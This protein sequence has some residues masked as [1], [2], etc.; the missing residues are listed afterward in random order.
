MSRYQPYLLSLLRII[1]GFTFIPHGCQKLFGWL[2]GMGGKGGTAELF[3]LPWIAGVLELFG[4][5]LILLGLFTRPV[6]FVLAGQ[7]AAAYFLA[8]AT[9]GF[10][11]ILNAGELAVVYCFVFFYIFLRG[12]G[13]WS[14]DAMMGRRKASGMTLP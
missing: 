4:G 2:G 6:A 3:S 12:S 9:R 1:V 7:M 14:I 13:S 11:P 5:L 8:H 10:W